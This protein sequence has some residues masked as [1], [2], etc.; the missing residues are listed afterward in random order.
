[1]FCE[2][3]FE[4]DHLKRFAGKEKY[5]SEARSACRDQY[6]KRAVSGDLT[7]EWTQGMLTAYVLVEIFGGLE[8]PSTLTQY[9]WEI[10]HTYANASYVDEHLIY[11]TRDWVYKNA[12]TVDKTF[13]GELLS[14]VSYQLNEILQF[15]LDDRLGNNQ[16]AVCQDQFRTLI[17]RTNHDDQTLLDVTM[18]LLQIFGQSSVREGTV[19]IGDF[20][21]TKPQFELMEII[22]EFTHVN[23][24]EQ[25]GLNVAVKKTRGK[26]S[27]RPRGFGRNTAGASFSGA[28]P[29]RFWVFTPCSLFRA[30]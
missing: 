2:L 19:D 6:C 10:I 12:Y 9:E 27:S 26:D 3:V 23:A 13:S 20:M 11:T 22:G 24:H 15:D 1:M 28:N 17:P 18:V 4:D 8:S 29:E 7:A 16:F 25:R 14:T 30:Q 5:F 21:T